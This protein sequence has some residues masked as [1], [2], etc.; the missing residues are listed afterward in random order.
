M[1]AFPRSLGP[2]LLCAIF[3]LGG[4]SHARGQPAEIPVPRPAPGET[5]EIEVPA[6][7]RLIF[8]FLPLEPTPEESY[9]DLVL[10]FDDG[11]RVILR[12]LLLDDR[13]YVVEVVFEGI[14]R[15][16]IVLFANEATIGGDPAAGNGG[17]NGD[18]GPPELAGLRHTGRSLL[19]PGEEER[20][21]HPLYSYLLYSGAREGER[22]ERL[23][24]RA[25]IEAFV[26]QVRSAEDL[27]EAGAAREEINIFYAPMRAYF[28]DTTP[29]N[30]RVDFAQRSPEEQ[31]D[32][33]LQHYDQARADVLKG[34]LQ[35][36]GNG[37]FI[38]SVLRPLTREAVRQDE[39]FLVQDLSGVPPELVA[40]WVDEF[41]RQVV[42]E[43]TETPEHLRRL[44]LNLRTRIA[45]LAEAF[46]ITKSAVA[47]MFEE[48]QDASEDGN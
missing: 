25:A 3:L 44:A 43:A 2:F 33:L 13:P 9:P 1:S 41:K 27:E 10:R 22:E 11:A 24:F 7:A 15:P 18:P 20:P 35:L 5:L 42:Q 6:E 28:T 38:V 26:G 4:V 48:P 46:A 40:L 32:L 21:G 23:R 45:V 39:A 37:P 36:S 19:F 47:E 8:A 14:A 12:N 16:A 17:H 30:L 29:D 34:R 31:V